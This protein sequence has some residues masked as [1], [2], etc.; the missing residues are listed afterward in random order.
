MS[1]VVRE[2]G[3]SPAKKAEQERK[4]SQ[5]IYVPMLRVLSCVSQAGKSKL[6][7]EVEMWEWVSYCK[8]RANPCHVIDS[9]CAG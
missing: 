5:S 7:R 2:T 6:Y 3:T 1:E 9:K 4:K 8:S